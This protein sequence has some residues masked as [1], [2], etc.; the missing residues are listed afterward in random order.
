MFSLII[1][2]AAMTATVSALLNNQTTMCNGM[3]DVMSL[4]I[5]LFLICF[6]G[7]L[8]AM[9]IG[10]FAV[11]NLPPQALEGHA[12]AQANCEFAFTG[13]NFQAFLIGRQI[14]VTMS[15]FLLA[16]ITTTNVEAHE[17]TVLGMP[18]GLQEFF[19]T[20]LPG[21]LITTIVASLAWRIIASTYPVAFMSNPL[22]YIIIRLCLALESSGVFSAS[23]LLASTVKAAARLKPDD[24]YL[25]ELMGKKK[26][27]SSK[28]L[29]DDDDYTEATDSIRWSSSS[30][31]ESSSIDS[32][33][34]ASSSRKHYGST[35][36]AA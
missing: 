26:G 28:S 3:S 33:S 17:P 9:Q 34:P 11:V 32:G 27:H 1:L 2:G 19:N 31:S 4:L 7:M 14:C 21:A 25:P 15:M 20:G 35:T 30:I 13:N 29:D 5:L 12:V 24:E 23:W 22:V 36:A 18:G 8:E 16:R 6:L 10:L